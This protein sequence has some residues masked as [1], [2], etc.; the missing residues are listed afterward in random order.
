VESGELVINAG[1]G[2]ETICATGDLRIS[3]AHNHMNILSAALAA[4]IHGVGIE[5]IRRTATA[6]PGVE[7]RLESVRMLD[8][9][10]W[11]NDSKATNVDSVVTAL[12]SFDRPIVLIAGG[13]D[14]EAPYDPLFDLV[15]AKVRAAVLI[16]EAADRID[17]ALGDKTQTLRAGSMADAIEAARA[18]ARAGDVV[19]LSPACS[20]FDMFADFEERG[21]VFKQLVMALQPGRAA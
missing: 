8:G 21:R 12:Q 3:G 5:D 15:R 4:R 16:G 11:I 19:V 2:N 9:V 6:F 1:F 7:H 10:E 14:K 18:L 13:R 20:S 17:A